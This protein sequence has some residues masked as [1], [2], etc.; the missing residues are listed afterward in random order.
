MNTL[1]EILN[2]E[3]DQFETCWPQIDNIIG[4]IRSGGEQVKAWEKVVN[5]LGSAP[6]SKGHPYFRL[7][8]LHLQTDADESVAISCLE[9]AYREDQQYGPNVGKEP[10]RMGA[11]RLLSLTKGFLAY[12]RKQE[13]WQT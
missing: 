10:H 2:L 7:A 11:Y 13:N 9:L 8:V 3:P 5:R 6:I 4:G 1:N 12:L